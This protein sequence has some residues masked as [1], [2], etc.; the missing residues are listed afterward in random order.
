LRSL[1]VVQQLAA[2]A[3][4]LEQ[5]AARVVVLGVLLEVLGQVVDPRG[6]E[7]DLHFRRTGVVLRALV[8]QEDL[9]LV[10]VGDCHG[11]ASLSQD[12][13]LAAR[14]GRFAVRVLP[15]ACCELRCEL[16][17]AQSAGFGMETNRTRSAEPVDFTG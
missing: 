5:A 7:G 4:H 9:G 16:S 14:P 17:S 13:G 10:D 15:G 11:L 8:V 3:H 1:Q 12:D 6:Q 2:T